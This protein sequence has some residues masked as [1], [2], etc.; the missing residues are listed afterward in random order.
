M[1][2]SSVAN[3]TV[4]NLGHLKSKWEMR[5]N[6]TLG[7]YCSNTLTLTELIMKNLY[8]LYR[9]Q[10]DEHGRYRGLLQSPDWMC[11]YS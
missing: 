1:H 11:A 7:H 9:Q 4:G 3:K 6:T 5:I 2:D 10:P 8:K